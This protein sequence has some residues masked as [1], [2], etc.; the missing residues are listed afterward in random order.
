MFYV[1]SILDE[2]RAVQEEGAPIRHFRRA[3]VIQVGAHGVRPY[4]T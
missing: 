2:Q 1:S 3:G 4:A